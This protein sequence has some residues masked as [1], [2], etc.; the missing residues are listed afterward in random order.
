MF[1]KH[2]I[3]IVLVYPTYFVSQ[4]TF[5]SQCIEHMSLSCSLFLVVW[6]I[7]DCGELT[8]VP[9]LEGTSLLNYHQFIRNFYFYFSSEL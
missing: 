7:S 2:S 5:W 3:N 1:V 8:V 9:Q 4:P 6:V